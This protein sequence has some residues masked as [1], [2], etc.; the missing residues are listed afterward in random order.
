MIVL[1]LCR[2]WRGMPTDLEIPFRRWERFVEEKNAV[3]FLYRL[4]KWKG[5]PCTFWR[6]ESGCTSSLHWTV[7]ECPGDD[8]RELVTGDIETAIWDGVHTGGSK[9]SQRHVEYTGHRLTL[10]CILCGTALFHFAV[11]KC[12]LRVPIGWKLWRSTK[13]QVRIR[14]FKNFVSRNIITL[15]EEIQW[16]K[17][18]Y[19]G[20]ACYWRGIN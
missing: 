13:S 12:Q 18:W 11:I 20:T 9:F 7:P 6:G 16:V 14:K 2:L 17:W 1:W 15:E 3:M 19:I 5:I 4:I 8:F 10:I